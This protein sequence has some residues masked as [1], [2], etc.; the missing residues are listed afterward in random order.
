MIIGIAGH[1]RHGKDSIA[2]VLAKQFAFRKDALAEPMKAVMRIVFPTWGDEHLYGRLKDIVDPV[3]GISPRHALQ[4]FGTQWAQQ[5]LSKYDSFRDTTGRL[6]WVRGLLARHTGGNLAVSDVRFPHEAN[7]LRRAG[8]IILMVR[9]PGYP[10]DMS[11]ESEQGV[12]EIKPD[13]VIRNGGT[14]DCLADE[15]C[16]FCAEIGIPPTA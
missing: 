3:Y 13:Y 10:V 12:E 1:A 15:V 14:L 7:E 9:R 11:H 16:K 6:I 2:D 4:S 8:A 5:E